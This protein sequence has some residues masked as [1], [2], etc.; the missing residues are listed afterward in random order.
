M[1]EGSLASF[2]TALTT[3]EATIDPGVLRVYPWRPP[4]IEAP[5][6]YN[7]VLPSQSDIPATQIVRD[8]MNLS[9]R[10][11]MPSSADLTEELAAMVKYFDLVRDVI[12]ADLVQPAHSV[13]RGACH[14]ARRTSSRTLTDVF[15][16][17]PYMVLEL[18]IAAEFRRGFQPL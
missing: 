9:V 5:A 18:V 3:L 7:W 12:D 14:N 11:V 1:A 10:V 4:T 16:N 13:L 17:I 15:N 8:T 2:I 6:I